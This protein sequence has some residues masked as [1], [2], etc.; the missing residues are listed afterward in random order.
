MGTTK[1]FLTQAMT[2]LVPQG[3]VRSDPG[4]TG[5]YVAVFDPAE[6][7]VLEVIE[8]V[9]GPDDTGRA[10][11][12]IGPAPVPAADCARC[13]G[14]GP[15]HGRSSSSSWRPALVSLSEPETAS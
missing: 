7:T 6:L 13:T 10:C 5:G 12:R 11:S 9:E 1:G 15:A 4:P 3:W 14:P 2:P 8:A